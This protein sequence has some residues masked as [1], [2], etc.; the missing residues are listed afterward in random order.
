[1]SRKKK[2]L[3]VL[4]TSDWHLGRSLYGRKRYEEQ[5]AFLSWLVETLAREEA[6]ILLVAGDIFDSSMP[7][8]RAQALYY[9]FLWRVATSSCRHVVLIAGNHDSPAFLG[10]PKELLKALK[11]RVVSAPTAQAEEEVLVLEDD[12]G[13]A[14]AV[15][16]AV[17]YLRDRDIR[18]VEAGESPEDKERNL[19]EGI[20]RH[21]A[22]VVALAEA[23]REE[24][25]GSPPLIGMGHLFTAGGKSV[26]GDGVRDLYVGSLAHVPA[27]VFPQSLAYVA[28]GHLHL[29]QAVDGA[30]RVRYSG[31]PLP[32]SFAEAEREKV[33]LLAEFS[34]GEVV[35]RGLAVPVF[36]ELER[37]TGEKEALLA[38]IRALREKGSRAW[39][40]IVFNGGEIAANLREELEEAVRGSSLE[41]LRVKNERLAERALA[42]ED[43]QD[44][45]AELNALEVFE[46]CLSAHEVPEAQR[47][48]L[49]LAYQEALRSL[50]EEGSARQGA[51]GVE[52]TTP[53]PQS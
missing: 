11:V 32:M 45:L 24:L 50:Y 28:L 25:G 42:Q 3:R 34:G 14:E 27:S 53:G 41:V 37:I 30:G 5:E 6:D 15:V 21:Y 8:T 33:V 29:P 17:P 31:S 20:R 44:T 16:C 10:A 7:S 48:D 2:P 43:A 18:T 22:E 51:P 4:H 40:E 46:R 1:M 47:P 52:P 36:Q 9:R 49:L 39:L 38:R 35:T 13:V 19:Q 12:A 23:R 26:D